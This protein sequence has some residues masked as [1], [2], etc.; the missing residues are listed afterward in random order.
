MEF[1]YYFDGRFVP[2]TEAVIPISHRGYRMADT[3]FD[4][5]RTFN[6]DIFRLDDHLERLYRSLKA[7]RIV[8]G[9]AQDEMAEICREVVRRNDP[10]RQQYGDFWVTQL[11]SRGMGRNLL[12]PEP[13]VVSVVVDPLP[14]WR[15]AG[16]YAQGAHLV[17]PATRRTAPDALDPKIKSTD[18]LSLVMAEIEAKQVDPEAYPLP[19]DDHGNLTEIV[20]GNLF[21]VSGGVVRTPGPRSI[22]S[23]ISR[24][25]TMEM[26]RSLDIPVVEE[27]LQP[28]DLYVAD[29]AF[30]TTTSFCI[31]PVGRFNGAPVGGHVPGSITKRLTSAWNEMVGLDIIE[32]AERYAGG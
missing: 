10:L 1:T 28:Y 12:Q 24:Q 2:A 23:G 4:T 18:R 25:T 5:E 16:L 13:A 15:H 3:V 9:L 27:D 20:S 11:V 14:F 19:L 7:V 26:A 6:G 31:L 29:E 32:Q 17:T 21:L 22:L 30:V 8:P